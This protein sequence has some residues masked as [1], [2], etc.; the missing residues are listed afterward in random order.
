MDV[1]GDDIKKIEIFWKIPILDINLDPRVFV[2][3]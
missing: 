1:R 2:L 3:L